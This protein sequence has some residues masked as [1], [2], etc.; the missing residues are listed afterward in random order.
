MIYDLSMIFISIFL[1]NKMLSIVPQQ[2]LLFEGTL[3]DIFHKR[4]TNYMSNQLNPMNNAS[5]ISNM[6]TI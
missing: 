6:L 3:D 1:C 5:I 4:I 2:P